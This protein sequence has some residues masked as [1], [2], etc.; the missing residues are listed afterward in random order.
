MLLQRVLSA[1]VLVPVVLAATYY[2]GPWF[3]AIVAIAALLAGYEYFRL[4]QSGGY[5]PAYGPGLLLIALF[6]LEGFFPGWRIAGGGLA[7]ISMALMT[8][9]VFQGNAPL[10]MA[11]WALNLAGAVYIGW[12]CHHFVALR[13]LDKGL[14]WVILLFAITWICDSAAYFVGHAWGR[15]HFFPKISPKKTREGAI[16]GVIAGVAT[17]LIVGAIIA[18]P[19]YHALAIGLLTTWGATFG[20]LS[21]SVIK[22]QVGVKDSGHL[23]P[24]HGGMLDRIDSLLFNTVLL[25]YY[26]FWAMGVR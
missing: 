12:G 10:S 18:I 23:I 5:R 21:E 7:L 17:S 16:A 14:Y 19:W 15:H 4:L 2:G 9:Q 11:N 3:F 22:R 26:L 1:I 8:W 24:G 25:Y 6:L 13:A 20:D